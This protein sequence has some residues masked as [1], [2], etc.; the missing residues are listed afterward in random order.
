M[1]TNA[2]P[3]ESEPAGAVVTMTPDAISLT[4]P[5]LTV[6]EPINTTTSP[7]WTPVESPKGAGIRPVAPLTRTSATSLFVSAPATKPVYFWPEDVV[8]DTCCEPA[9]RL[10]GVTTVPM[11]SS[12]RPLPDAVPVSMRTTDGPTWLIRRR[13]SAWI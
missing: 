6:W 10:A 11:E 7:I 2:L 8:I 1:F 3:D 13:R 9:T 12:S 4:M 5:W